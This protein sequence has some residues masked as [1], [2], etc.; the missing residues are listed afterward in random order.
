MNP[1][2]IFRFLPSIIWMTFIYYLSSLQTTGISGTR[3][4]RFLILKTFHLIEYAALFIFLFFA[5]K[6]YLPSALTAYLYA[7]T[8]ELHQSLVPGREGKFQDTLIDLLGILLGL[9]LLKIFLKIPKV[10]KIL[11]L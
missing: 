3:T 10:K 11:S 6:K 7:L 8:D 5:L 1:K 2:K 9:A 4:E